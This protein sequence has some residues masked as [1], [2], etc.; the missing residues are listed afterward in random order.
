[1]GDTI[2]QP[3]SVETFSLGQHFITSA[4]PILP[5]SQDQPRDDLGLKGT[6]TALVLYLVKRKFPQI[7]SESPSGKN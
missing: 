5:S 6:S 3:L 7:K 4:Y 1:M 2:F